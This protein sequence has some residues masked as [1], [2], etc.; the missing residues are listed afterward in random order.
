MRLYVKSQPYNNGAV[1]LMAV[2]ESTKKTNNKNILAAVNKWPLNMV[3]RD[4]TH[5]HT[6]MFCAV[7]KFVSET[8]KPHLFLILNSSKGKCPFIYLVGLV[9]LWRILSR[10]DQ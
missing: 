10:N 7:L 9:G 4:K 6:I 3:E 2:T 5:R 1:I 8:M